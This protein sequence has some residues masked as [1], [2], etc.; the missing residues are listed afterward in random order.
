MNSPV[1]TPE[2]VRAFLLTRYADP[3]R[4]AGKDP[5][6]IPDN[7]DF[8]MEG[9]IDSLGILE[10]VSAVEKEARPASA[11]RASP[12]RPPPGPPPPPPP[13]QTPPSLPPSPG[14]PAY[15]SRGS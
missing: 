1:V 7:F 12:A 4:G 2:T 3:I 9:V 5:A 6:Q 13:P 15:S 8:L 11:P 10:M 14:T